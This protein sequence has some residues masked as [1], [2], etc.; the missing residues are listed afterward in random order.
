MDNIWQSLEQ[1]M[2]FHVGGVAFAAVT[3]FIVGVI[4]LYKKGLWPGLPICLS[5]IL[6]VI[7][8]M[9]GKLLSP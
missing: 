3:I 8:A 9:L 7:I 2:A 5:S 1:I 4:L 6:L